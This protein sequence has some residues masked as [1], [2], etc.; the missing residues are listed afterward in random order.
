VALAYLVASCVVQPLFT[1]ITV[2]TLGLTLGDCLAS[3]LGVLEAGAGMLLLVLGARALLLAAGVTPVVRLIVLVVWGA[4]ATSSSSRGA[5]RKYEPISSGCAGGGRRLHQ[6]VAWP[7]RVA[8]R[9][10]EVAGRLS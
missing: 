7:R 2:R 5:H 1:A 6:P 4:C 3:I 8:D 9:R 10:P